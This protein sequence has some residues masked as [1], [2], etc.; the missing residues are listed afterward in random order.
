VRCFGFS[1][2]VAFGLSGR[3]A[4]PVSREGGHGARLDGDRLEWPGYGAQSFGKLVGG[5]ALIILAINGVQSP[6]KSMGRVR[7]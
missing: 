3:E 6:A 2:D 7:G 4:S 5:A 1:G